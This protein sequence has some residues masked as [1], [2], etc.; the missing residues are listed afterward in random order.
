MDIYSGSGALIIIHHMH[1]CI[2]GATPGP[3]SICPFVLALMHHW[4][5]VLPEAPA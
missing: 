2:K 5:Q 1:L 3:S 4:A